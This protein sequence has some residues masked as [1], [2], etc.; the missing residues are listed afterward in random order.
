MA[1]TRTD[2]DL[3]VEVA[4]LSR[5]FGSGSSR[6]V[7]LEDVTFT[8]GHG[9]VVGLLGG[10]GAGKT[11]LTKILATLLLP[12]SGHVQVFGHDLLR[13]PATARRLTGVVLGGDRGLYGKL[14]G[15]DN[16]R[17][18]A[19][20]G[21][22]SR[23]GLTDRVEQSLDEVGLSEVADRAVE[24]YSKGMKQRLHVAVGMFNR[25][26]L[27]LLDE[28][29]VGLDPTEAERLRGALAV[30]REQGVAVLLTSHQLLDVERL[31]DRVLVLDDGRIA[32][33]L[34][35]A[36][37]AKLAGYAATVIVRGAGPRPAL[38]AL[39]PA[40]VDVESVS[41]TG[42]GGWIARLR[43]REWGLDALSSLGRALADVSVVDVQVASLRLEDVYGHVV[44]GLERA[45]S[46]QPSS[47]APPAARR[48]E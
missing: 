22:A 14:N 18:F 7:A 8:I 45:R 6:V 39:V 34:G 48:A 38:S 26:R 42:D 3:A 24:T 33:D 31:A 4:H 17:F 2:S 29:T 5:S 36:E 13:D 9:E 20:L 32:A 44:G 23:R 1:S 46:G 25:P 40:A 10:N 41:D 21:G 37:F 43:V 12:T 28:P 15:R 11:T 35:I 19:V 30:L 16:L 27:L 47:P